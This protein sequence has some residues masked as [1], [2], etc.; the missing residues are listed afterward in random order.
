MFK[1]Q[2][3]QP[4]AFPPLVEV[5]TQPDQPRSHIPPDASDFDPLQGIKI[6]CFG[7]ELT[8]VRFAGARD[9]RSGCHTAKQRLDHLYPYRIVGWHTK[10]SFLKVN[11]KFS[12]VSILYPEE[13]WK[14]QYTNHSIP[15]VFLSH[16]RKILGTRLVH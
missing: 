11:L 1:V 13:W 14:F 8:R 15:R 4:P 2:P 7:D 12:S 16:L 9:L 10:R 5:P 3:D 6:P